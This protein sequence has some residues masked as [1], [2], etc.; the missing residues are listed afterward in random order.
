M[1]SILKTLSSPVAVVTGDPSRITSPESRY[2][3]L[4]CSTLPGVFL[5]I[6]Y[7]RGENLMKL[8]RKIKSLSGSRRG[9][10]DR[11]DKRGESPRTKVAGRWKVRC[12]GKET[13][14]GV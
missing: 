2:K 3:F 8:G 5:R 6:L 4:T 12:Q 7:D 11:G 14:K 10:K 9:K 1:E 13:I